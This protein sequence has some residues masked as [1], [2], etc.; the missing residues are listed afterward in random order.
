MT[1]VTI[2]KPMAPPGISL[3]RSTSDA[4]KPDWVSAQAMADA[5]PMISRMAPESAAASSIIG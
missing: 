5:M 3:I 4:E 1:M 2:M